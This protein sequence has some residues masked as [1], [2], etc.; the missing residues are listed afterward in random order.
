M[1]LMQPRP[2]DSSSAYRIDQDYYPPM[3]GK[4]CGRIGTEKCCN[5]I[6]LSMGTFN[7]DDINGTAILALLRPA[8]IW[9][10]IR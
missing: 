6:V 10:N 3:P 9:L 4:M 8:F 2:N 7:A 1:F 5:L